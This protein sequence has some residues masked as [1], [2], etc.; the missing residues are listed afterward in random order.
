MWSMS[1]LRINLHAKCQEFWLQNF[2][3]KFKCRLSDLMKMPNESFT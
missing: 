1:V 3:L 2:M